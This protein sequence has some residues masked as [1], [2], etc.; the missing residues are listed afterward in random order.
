MATTFDVVIGGGGVAGRTAGLFTARHNLDTL[1]LDAG[2]SIV[3]R[4]AHLENSPGLS[5]GVDARWL[6]QTMRE[7]VADA[8][9]A[10]EPC[11]VTTVTTTASADDT[12][13]AIETADG[14]TYRARSVIAATKHAV[15]PVQALPDVG[16]VNRG[17]RFIAVGDRG[18]TDCDGCSAAGRVAGKPHQAI[19]A[20]GHGAEVA[21]SFLD[22]HDCPFYH[23][24]VAPEGYF[25]GRGREVPPGCEEIDDGQRQRREQEAR[26]ALCDHLKEPFPEEPEQHPSVAEGE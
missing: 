21:C 25:T 16:I 3:R 11:E 20:A 8:G 14:N 18:R 26:A 19:V 24:W 13:F 9:C 2:S 7:Q 5:A 6:L 4:T 12:R 15:A 23:D 17:K 10:F 1:V 22:D